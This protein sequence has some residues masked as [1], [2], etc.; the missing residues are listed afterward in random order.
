MLVTK[1]ADVFVYVAGKYSDKT[2][3][4]TER[5]VLDALELS[6]KCAAHG[7][8]FFCPHTHSK[9]FDL[10]APQVSWAYWMDLDIRV[11]EKLINCM[12]MVHN[13]ENSKGA[14]LEEATAKDLGYPVFYNFNDF[15]TWYNTLED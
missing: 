9:F 15:I 12:L 5:H 7:I 14:K 1:K 2:V 13:Y 6:I 8:H 4:K 11:I 10:Y 3:L